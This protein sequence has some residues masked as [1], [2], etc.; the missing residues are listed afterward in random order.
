M[1]DGT[2]VS[3]ERGT[4]QGAVV[5]PILANLFLH[6][7][8]DRWMQDRYPEV[9]FER[10]ADDIVCHCR[11]EAQTRS[12]WAALEVRFEACK[13]ELHPQK[14]KIVYCKDVNRHGQHPNQKFDFLGY[15][16][17]PRSAM[18][19]NGKL[20]VSFAPAVSDKAAANLRQRVRRWRLHRR[21]DLALVDLAQWTRPV[22]AGWVRYYGRFHP[23]ALCRALRTLDPFLVRWAQRK[24]RRLRGRYMRAWDWLRRVQTRQPRLFA[25][26]ISE[27][28]VGR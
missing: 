18:N 7:T 1:P 3:R 26:W 9:P 27:A 4:P 14:T 21:N 11:S 25:H 8:F 22:L 12:L 20:F 2:L 17:R 16:F 15:T 13:L 19:R 24:Y 5:S 6:Y 23:S 28:T 10:Y